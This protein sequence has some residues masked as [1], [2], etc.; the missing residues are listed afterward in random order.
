MTD[1]WATIAEV[2]PVVAFAIVLEAR[3]ITLS[4]RQTKVPKALRVIQSLIW[5]TI[6]IVFAFT[7]TNA[8]Q[9][10]R[11]TEPPGWLPVV[12]EFAIS[13]GMGILVLSPAVE[14][15]VRANPEGTARILTVYPIARGRLW[16]L[17]RRALRF[18]RQIDWTFTQN[19]ADIGEARDTIEELESNLA[20]VEREFIRVRDKFAPEMRAAEEERIADTRSR[21]ARG[22]ARWDERRHRLRERFAEH[23][24]GKAAYLNKRAQRPAQWREGILKERELLAARFATFSVSA[25]ISP[26]P[27]ELLVGDEKIEESTAQQEARGNDA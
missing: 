2:I 5:A 22:K 3:A 14:V 4:W 12:T 16:Y 18:I 15:M 13:G 19:W 10:V 11:G 6:L 24:R 27:V 21:I 23:E 7:E 25:P 9:A 8:L 26:P 17:D 20:E 1:Y